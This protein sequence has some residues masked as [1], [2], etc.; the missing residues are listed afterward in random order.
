MEKRT[1]LDR[2]LSSGQV[3]M[4]GL[5]GALGTGL[6]LGSGTTIELAGPATVISY[7][8]AGSLALAIVWAL[9]EMVSVHPVPGGHGAVAGQYLGT[10]GGYIARWNF[11]IQSFVAVGAEVVATATYLQHWFPHLS[12]G[13][14]T[15]FC[16][17][18]VLGLNFATVRL[19]GS[20]EYWFSM[21]KVVAICAFI[22]LGLSLI[23]TGWPGSNPPTGFANLSAHGGFMPNGIGGIFLAACMAVFSFGGIEN[24]SAGAAESEHPERDIPR[25]AH[26]M[27]WRLLIFYILAVGVIVTMQPWQETAAGGTVET[28]P[29]VK[30]LDRAG[31]GAAGNIMNF[32]LIVAALSAAN[33][34][35]YASSRMIHSLALDSMAPKIAARTSA[36]GSPRV[37]VCIAGIGMVF[38]SLLAIF[39]ADSAFRYLMGCVILAILVTWIIVLLTHLRFRKVRKMQG[40]PDAPARLWGAP[41]VNFLG[42]LACICVFAVLWRQIPAAWIAGI[43]YLILLFCSYFLWRRF[44]PEYRPAALPEGH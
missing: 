34:C 40:K 4:I 27:I 8:I 39:A 26:T 10:C 12:L 20:S 15:V 19:Y 43:P 13:L 38:A 36:H 9:A 11:G 30:A 41:A 3:A 6:F 21:I 16:S 14:G 31:V 32:I 23:F 22:L 33:G 2:R 42:I 18:F 44:H 25:A 17:L 37:A 1:H 7:V 5:S 29:F 24:A 28:S 35:L